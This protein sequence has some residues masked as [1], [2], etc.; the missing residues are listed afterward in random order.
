[1][2]AN[3]PFHPRAPLSEST[4]GPPRA[5]HGAPGTP[6]APNR[7]R[8]AHSRAANTNTRD[9]RVELIAAA[10][11]LAT[12]RTPPA[13]APRGA[14]RGA[15]GLRGS[16]RT[17]TATPRAPAWRA[18]AQRP[19]RQLQSSRAR[20]TSTR[21]FARNWGQSPSAPP[22]AKAPFN[23]PAR[24]S[25][26][27]Y[28]CRARGVW[29][30]AR[31]IGA[32]P[33]PHKHHPKTY[34][35]SITSQRARRRGGAARRAPRASPPRAP[36]SALIGAP[37]RTGVARA[38]QIPRSAAVGGGGPKVRAMEPRGGLACHVARPPPRSR[39]RATPRRPQAA[40][41]AHSWPPST[42]AWGWG[43]GVARAMGGAAGGRTLRAAR[44]LAR[45]RR[46]GGRARRPPPPRTWALAET[47][48][49]L[50]GAAVIFSE[51]RARAMATGKEGAR[52]ANTDVMNIGCDDTCNVVCVDIEGHRALRGGAM[53]G[54][55]RS[56]GCV[57]RRHGARWQEGRDGLRWAS[58]AG[59][60]PR[61][62]QV[63]SSYQIKLLS[64]RWTARL[65]FLACTSMC[66]TPYIGAHFTYLYNCAWSSGS[67]LC[68]FYTVPARW[69]PA[70]T[71]RLSCRLNV[72]GRLHHVGPKS[73]RRVTTTCRASP[74]PSLFVLSAPR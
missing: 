59:E 34:P 28:A 43:V 69:Q 30:R 66:Q 16:L 20:V 21:A 52:R 62:V 49:T 2:G 70:R 31:R 7:R 15:A 54:A 14:C 5:P 51:A 74:W 32:A 17:T 4:I 38:C 55:S 44:A 53:R 47:R 29:R 58:G 64:C 19:H 26:N 10:G 41:G 1:M 68:P 11:W 60:P 6:A 72:A 22:H 36:H 35:L 8:P 13:T 42:A 45:A 71:T 12:R 39:H 67:L 63:S 25:R 23:D 48:A 73:H 27:A 65:S 40:P 61:R 37:T 3:C 9:A 18:A 56:G 46:P 50:A 33:R 57:W 24:S